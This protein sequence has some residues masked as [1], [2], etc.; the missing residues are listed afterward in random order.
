MVLSPWFVTLYTLIPMGLAI[1]GGALA[2]IYLPKPK[3]V[4]MLQHFVAGIVIGAVA[5]ELLPKILGHA[6]PISIGV[7][8]SAGVVLMF[9]L[10]ELSHLLSSKQALGLIIAAAVDL[11]IDGMLIGISFLAGKESGLLI[12]I[13]LSLCAFFLNLSVSATLRQKKVAKLLQWSSLLLIALMLPLGALIGSAVVGQFSSAILYQTLAFGVAALLYL[14]VE[15]LLVEAHE[16]P[17]SP[18][19]C[20]TFFLGFLVILLFRI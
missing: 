5:I 18:W 15:E 1:L 7:G 6:S 20:A 8:F 3:V 9:L 12:A 13:S 11:F 16:G 10:H 14:G 17:E 4:S 19:V 2:S